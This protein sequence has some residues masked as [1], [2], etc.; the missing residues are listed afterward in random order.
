VLNDLGD[1]GNM[2][3]SDFTED[4]FEDPDNATDQPIPPEDTNRVEGALRFSVGGDHAE[5]SM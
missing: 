4:T 1:V 2:A 3:R 5:H